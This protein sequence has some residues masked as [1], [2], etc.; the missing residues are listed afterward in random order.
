VEKLIGRT[1]N[2]HF[3]RMVN[4]TNS[5]TLKSRI[6]FD[7]IDHTFITFEDIQQSTRVF[8]PN[9]EVAII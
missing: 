1:K 7:H 6:L 5:T 2:T 9:E 4:P 8:I 3:Y